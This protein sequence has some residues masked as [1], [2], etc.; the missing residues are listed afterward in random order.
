MSDTNVKMN[1]FSL[2]LT[3]RHKGFHYLSD[4]IIELR[5]DTDM[6][7]ALERV[8]AKRNVNMTYFDNSMRYAINYA[9]DMTNGH[10]HELFPN[11]TSAPM[12]IEFIFMMKWKMEAETVKPPR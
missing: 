4:A 11:Y 6:K 2:G 1:L 5:G 10:I 7:D 9:W 8:C 12:P 3:P